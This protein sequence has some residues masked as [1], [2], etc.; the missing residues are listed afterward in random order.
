[1]HAYKQI[2]KLVTQTQQNTT[3]SPSVFNLNRGRRI[4]WAFLALYSSIDIYSENPIMLEQ[5]HDKNIILQTTPMNEYI[6]QKY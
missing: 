4:N 1:M 5:S 2:D 6:K 3:F